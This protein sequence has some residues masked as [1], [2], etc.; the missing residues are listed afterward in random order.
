MARKRRSAAPTQGD[1][2]TAAYNEALGQVFGHPLFE[3]MFYWGRIT[4]RE[5][6]ACPEDAY[7][8]VDSHGTVHVHPKK[9]LDV[10]EW[11][12]VLAHCLLHLGLGHFREKPEDERAWNT[13]CDCF[14]ARMLARMK[15]GRAPGEFRLVPEFSAKDEADLYERFRERG[16]PDHL[17]VF[18]TA[19]PGGTDMRWLPP[20]KYNPFR[21]HAD[22]E[23]RFAEGLA[24]AV[25][26]A[27]RVAAGRESAL[28]A[29]DEKMTAA[30]RARDWFISSYPLLGALASRFKVIEDPILCA[31]LDV[32][33]A[34]V[35]AYLGE[36]YLNPAAALDEAECRFV[37]AH[38]LLHVALRHAARR[39]GRDP[40]LWNAACDY[41]LN[42]WLVEMQVGVM[43]KL[44]V[45][46]DPSLKGMSA[47]SIYDLL[48][49]D[50]RRNRKLMTLRG[51]GIGDMLERD[52]GE[53]W[54]RGDGVDLDAF[55]RSALAQGHRYHMEQGRG[56]LPADLEEEIRAIQQPEIPWDVELARWFENHFTPIE[57]VRSYI[58]PS[59]RQ[60]ATPDIPRPR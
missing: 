10:E 8:V 45:L 6:N 15:F 33:I 60:S 51:V 31:R 11:I 29:D 48:V 3:P 44:G 37:M 56:W 14:V 2:A 26:S 27:V 36:I 46:Y 9:R 54:C 28:G 22:W 39:R 21:G 42:Q 49:T 19:A 58:R 12:Y 52:H 34:A 4:R 57:K 24:A 23:E 25:R 7:A 32:S 17:G 47:E 50:M 1:P 40:F 5:G 59:R 41:V 18:G 38:E 20:E 30:Q 13:A 35:D 43:P 53:W 16:I 55:Y